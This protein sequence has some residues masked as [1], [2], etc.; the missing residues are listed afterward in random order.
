MDSLLRRHPHGLPA[1][2][3][4]SLSMREESVLSVFFEQFKDLLVIVLI[5]AAGISLASGHVESTIVIFAVILLNAVLGTLQTVKAEQSLASL[6]DMSAPV[7][8][9]M[10]G[11]ERV[12]ILASEVV[13]GDLLVLEAGDL[14]AADGRIVESFSLK[15][16]ESAL[17]GESSAVEKNS[18]PIEGDNVAI[19]DR[20][21]MVFSGSLAIYGRAYAVVTATGMAT[22]IGRIASLMNETKERKT[23]A[24]GKPRRLFGQAC[25]RGCDRLRRRV[26]AFGVS[27]RHRDCSIRSCSP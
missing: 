17:T 26:P 13:P 9:V 21:N 15:V 27:Q 8:R 11:G 23:P 19:G 16:N 5:A 1:S 2:A 7:A 14:I 24:A 22:E 20:E 18:L 3:K 12:E 10:R 6:K 4:I 25:H